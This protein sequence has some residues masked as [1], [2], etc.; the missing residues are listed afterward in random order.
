M[1]QDCRDES[2]T[3]ENLIIIIA[4]FSDRLLVGKSSLHLNF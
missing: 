1:N 4:N 3:L 2:R